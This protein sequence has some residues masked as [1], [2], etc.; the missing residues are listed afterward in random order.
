MAEDRTVSLTSRDHSGR[1]MC[2]VCV[3]VSNLEECVHSALTRGRIHMCA[4]RSLAHTYCCHWSPHPAAANMPRPRDDQKRFNS[5]SFPHGSLPCLI[6]RVIATAPPNALPPPPTAE[7]GNTM[8]AFFET[9]KTSLTQSNLSAYYR[10]LIALYTITVA[11]S[12][13]NRQIGRSLDRSAYEWITTAMDS[14]MST[15]TSA[16]AA[17][18]TSDNAHTDADDDIEGE[19]CAARKVRSR[20]Y[21]ICCWLSM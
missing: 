11:A 10:Y 5:H 3:V 20:L 21:Q 13:T 15:E 19:N 14:P 17:T 7:D 6:D 9:C 1:T 12:L 4:C 16:S 2:H 18:T 8:H